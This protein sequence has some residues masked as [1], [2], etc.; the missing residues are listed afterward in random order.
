MYNQIF[1]ITSLEEKK[2][3][4]RRIL[5]SKAPFISDAHLNKI[6]QFVDYDKQYT[7]KVTSKIEKF[8]NI[9][10]REHVE[11]TSQEFYS[12]STPIYGEFTPGLFENIYGI[13]KKKPSQIQTFSPKA[14][15]KEIRTLKDEKEVVEYYLVVYFPPKE[16]LKIS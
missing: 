7:I 13:I 5:K 9:V 14:A 1:H 4:L 2:N 10:V 6:I 15:I 12:H 16:M 3:K 11:T 8:K